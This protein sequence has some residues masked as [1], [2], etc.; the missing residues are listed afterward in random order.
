[1]GLVSDLIP[2]LNTILGARD[3][4]GVAL[5]TVKIVTRTWTGAEPGDGTA[6][7]VAVQMLPTPHIVEY[8]HDAEISS[9]GAVRAGDIKLKSISKQS[10]ATLAAVDCSS[11]SR[12][13][14]KFYEVGGALFQVI[15]VRERLVTWEVHLRR[16]SA[17]TRYP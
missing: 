8:G 12:S 6:A 17:Q 3:D 11:N 13:V 16:L 7:E 15:R 14:E 1:M 2:N 5:K 9:G 4:I 10:Y